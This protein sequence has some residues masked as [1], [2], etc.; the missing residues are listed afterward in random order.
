M[1]PGY[2][3]VY[4][5]ELKTSVRRKEQGRIRERCPF[6]ESD[7]P[8]VYV[9]WLS[10][11]PEARYPD[12][13]FSRGGRIVRRYG[14]RLMDRF[15]SRHSKKE[16]ALSKIERLTRDC[17]GRGW[18]VLT[19]PNRRSYSVYVIELEQR[20]LEERV[21]FGSQDNIDPDLPPVYVGK[22]S[23]SP[24][25]RFAKHRRNETSASNDVADFGLRLRPDLYESYNP[26]TELE[27][28]RKE[29]TLHQ[30]LGNLG[31]PV[32]GGH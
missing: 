21:K 25:E 2:T 19:P 12:D 11:P 6:S 22:T 16:G 4:G 31:F 13:D 20:I 30:M 7:K 32:A 5:V 26:M 14:T 8:C 18:S 3:Y 10:E 27:A 17:L 24:E 9:G 1:G 28:F 15:R 29:R 23:L